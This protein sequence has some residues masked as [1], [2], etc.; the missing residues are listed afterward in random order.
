MKVVFLFLCLILFYASG[1]SSGRIRWGLALLTRARKLEL[2]VVRFSSPTGQMVMD[3]G[4]GFGVWNGQIRIFLF[5][6]FLSFFL[7][8]FTFCMYSLNCMLL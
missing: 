5:P 7:S 2:E 1:N 6:S 3:P 8:F 4:T